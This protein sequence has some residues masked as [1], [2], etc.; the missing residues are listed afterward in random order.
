MW[1][2][3]LPNQ[4]LLTHGLGPIQAI[5]GLATRI[6]ALGLADVIGYKG[7]QHQATSP[8]NKRRKKNLRVRVMG[9]TCPTPSQEQTQE[10]A[11]KNNATTKKK[12]KKIHSRSATNKMYTLHKHKH[13]RSH[14]FKN[15]IG[16]RIEKRSSSHITGQIG[17]RSVVEHKHTRSHGFKNWIV[18]RTEKRSS[19][20]I[21]SRIGI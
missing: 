16:E 20:H 7:F 18:E 1:S 19:S 21:A 6:T 4:T 12:K 10:K 3:S 13:T 15:W 11:G 8:N 14:G 9:W 17:I 5:I 2:L